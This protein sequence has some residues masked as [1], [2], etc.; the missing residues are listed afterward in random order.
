M[1]LSDTIEA[2]KIV[3]YF[4]VPS[5]SL[6]ST[7]LLNLIKV[8]IND[9]TLS[10]MIFVDFILRKM[11]TTPLVEALMLALPMFLQINIGQID[12]ENV[13]ELVDLLTFVAHSN[14][15]Q[16]TVTNIVSALTLHGENL[17]V[18]EARAII[19]AICDL[20]RYFT[21][22][23]KLLNNAMN[24][25][26]KQIDDLPFEQLETTIEKLSNKFVNT[27]NP[28]F[29]DEILFT[30]ITDSIVRKKPKLDMAFYYLRKL[31]K[32]VSRVTTRQENFE[33]IS[34]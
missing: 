13:S 14:V 25:L 27:K 31:N 23:E 26:E 24:V 16:K 6:I 34:I 3:T 8:Q 33:S 32:I 4:G 12:H 17:T 15:S 11:E 1:T 10:E 22:C 19:W 5:K 9:L 20:N 30:E 21:N 7:I 29:Y 28:M 2:L 18:R